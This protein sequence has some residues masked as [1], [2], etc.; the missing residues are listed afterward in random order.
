M[1]HRLPQVKKGSAFLIISCTLLVLLSFDLAFVP[2]SVWINLFGWGS[3]NLAT[4]LSLNPSVSY[5]VGPYPNSVFSADL[6]NDGKLDLVTANGNS[7]SISILFASSAGTFDPKVD[8]SVGSNPSSVFAADLNNDGKL[9]IAVANFIGNS[10][11]VLLASSAGPAGTFDPKVDYPTGSQHPWSVFAADLNN[12]GKLDLATANP[13]SNS[14]SVFLAPSAGPAGTF[15]PRVDY[16]VGSNPRFIFVADLNN[17]GRQDLAVANDVDSSVSILLAPSAGPAGTFNPRVDYP[18]GSRPFSIFVSDINDDGKQDLLVGNF[19]E[20]SVSILLA[21]SAGTFDPKVDY[22]VGSSPRSVSVAD[23]NNDGKKDLVVANYG[24]DNI[25]VLL[26]SS[27]GPA[28][29]FDPKIDYSVGDAPS[30][31]VTA[32][33][34]NDGKQDLVTVNQLSANISVLL[35]TPDVPMPQAGFGSAVNYTVGPNP[36]SVFSADFNNDGKLDLAAANGGSNTVSIYLGNGTGG[37]N[38]APNLITISNPHGVTGGDFN[39]DGKQDL[40]VPNYIGG[41]FRVSIF[42]GDGSGGFVSAADIST[43]ANPISISSADFNNDGKLDLVVTEYR[44]NFFT[45]RNTVHVFLGNGLGG[46]TGSDSKNTGYIPTS[47]VTGDFNNDGKQDLAVESSS[48]NQINLFLGNGDG[49]FGPITNFAVGT[50]PA[51]MVASDFNND[52]KI[53]LVT[54]NNSGVSGTLSILM[55]NGSGGFLPTATI[56]GIGYVPSSIFASDFNNDG[57]QDLIVTKLNDSNISLFL[58]NGDG[59][60]LAPTIFV[61][62][63]GPQ[64]V[65]VGDFNHD[66]IKDLSVAN[67]NSNNLSILLGQKPNPVPT[68]TSIDQTSKMV[69]DS[70]FTLTVDGTNFMN[71][72]VVQFNGT[73]RTTTY[74]SAT[75]L[76]ADIPSSDLAIAGTFP[77]TVFNP[78]PGGGTSSPQTFTVN[79]PPPPP[80]NIN[81]AVSYQSGAFPFSIVTADFNNDTKPDLITTNSQK[82]ISLLTGNGDGTFSTQIL[83]NDLGSDS[84]S[85]VT[86][87][88]NN[89]GRPDLAAANYGTFQSGNIVI[90][91]GNGNGTFTSAPNINTINPALIFASDFNGDGKPDLAVIN[92]N[93]ANSVSIF[94]GDGTGG[95]LSLGTYPV[96]TGPDGIFA[97]DINN[98]GKKDLVVSNYGTN[99]VSILLGNGL[100]AFG[101]ASNLSV[102]SPGNIFTQDFNSDNKADIA[103]INKDNNSVST[104]LGNGDGTFGSVTVIPV[105]QDPNSIFASDINNDGKIDLE[106]TNRLS[107][108]VSVLLGYGN[109]SFASAINLD[110]G[111]R[112]RPIVGGDFNKDGVQDLAVGG[113]TGTTYDVHIL[114]GINPVPSPTITSLNPSLAVA[115]N[116][117]AFYLTIIGT[118]FSGAPIVRFN[119]GQSATVYVD[120]STQL[121]A[122]MLSNTT[123]VVGNFPVTVEVPG[124]GISNVYYF[125][126]IPAA[127]TITSLSPIQRT[128][129]DATT[130]LT[131]VGTNFSNSSI[132]RWDGSDLVTTY[133]DSTHLTAVIPRINMMTDGIYNILVFTPTPLGG[134][135]SNTLPFTV[136]VNP[137]IPSIP[138]SSPNPVPDVFSIGPTVRY[139]GD[140][141]FTLTVN[142]NDFVSNSVVRLNGVSKP[143]TFISINKLEATI[144]TADILNPGSYPVTVFN[145]APGGGV[146]GN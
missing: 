47:V 106:I 2:N 34:N 141:D 41:G 54:A 74:V 112:P 140:P 38:S 143:T 79:N 27:A 101:P 44:S 102:V 42:L 93:A 77:I 135:T 35:S 58:G 98:D 118:N 25:S 113:S 137:M 55:N 86:T 39:N 117:L 139:Q 94:T 85:M 6:N 26:A 21:S 95:F 116:G 29:T 73:S 115:G 127:P 24:S 121:R 12:D 92:G 1:Q 108:T 119:G 23:M 69:G 133:V 37:F 9:D 31:I 8:Y 82:T 64:S 109:G 84:I 19:G 107:D 51:A 36:N 145:P 96:G 10:I 59:T 146:S 87:D 62:G 4:V 16:P 76:T 104:F 32:D 33:L 75:Q 83:T 3:S 136:I 56:S 129:G 67:L 132:V 142:G 49:T 63:T 134:D 144:T 15:N 91:L 20:T 100:G 126:V 17:D 5:P 138:R 18:V 120:S 48:F 103:I 13:S 90:L 71:S 70:G 68:I 43:P 53:D 40:A 99:T 66:G 105:G 7:N 22:L 124:A 123:D 81:P 72:S 131:V 11:S 30:S 110:A 125:S 50:G 114:L 111:Q 130:T 122:L 28:G 60:F 57:K 97:S 46:F 61:A 89:D 14:A 65:F 52:G 45:P 80:F 78:T 88:F 128:V